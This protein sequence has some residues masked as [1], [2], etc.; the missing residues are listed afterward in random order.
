M[1]KEQAV[2][3]QTVEQQVAG[4][5]AVPLFVEL[6]AVLQ[7]LTVV[8]IAVQQL[9]AVLTVG[10]PSAVQIVELLNAEQIV[11]LLSVEQT[12]VQPNVELTV[13]LL[14]AGPTVEQPNVVP[15]VALPNAGRTAVPLNA[16]QTA[17]LLDVGQTVVLQPDAG[18]TV[19]LQPDVAP[20][21][22]QLRTVVLCVE[23]QP[24]IVKPT[25][26]PIVAQLFVNYSSIAEQVEPMLV[27]QVSPPQFVHLPLKCQSH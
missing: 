23:E 13:V 16:V 11:V 17:V 22:E 7:P 10:Q 20:T 21:A 24:E 12:V 6:T 3:E 8:L 18:Q 9:N 14:N 25:A 1:Q 4:L 27:V 19:V 2:A 26:V 5:I 15:T